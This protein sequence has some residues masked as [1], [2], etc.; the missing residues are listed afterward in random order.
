[1]QCERCW[2]GLLWDHWKERRDESANI[3]FIHVDQSLGCIEPAKGLHPLQCL[4]TEDSRA[5]SVMDGSVR[6]VNGHYQITLTWKSDT[7]HLPNDKS[8]A[9][10]RLQLLKKNGQR[11]IQSSLRGT[12]KLWETTLLKAMQ[13]GLL[14]RA[15]PLVMMMHLSGIC[16]TRS[17]ILRNQ[18]RFGSFLIVQKVSGYIIK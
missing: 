15:H 5:K 9:E 12:K 17:Y 18:K 3:N 14:S 7:P 13:W 8:L 2:A 1:M 6:M 16:H 10:K 4:S 11:G